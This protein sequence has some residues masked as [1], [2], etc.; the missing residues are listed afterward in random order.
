MNV[1]NEQ[2]YNVDK[3][4]GILKPMIYS[5]R[6]IWGFSFFFTSIFGG[7]LLMQNLKDIEKRKEANLVLVVSILLTVLTVVIIS[8]FN[9]QNRSVSFLCNIGA[10]GILTEIFY[11]KYFPDEADYDKKKI[12]KPLIIGICISVALFLLAVLIQKQVVS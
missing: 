2:D 1:A 11:K 8:F 12:W 10:A 6:A 3:L 4:E 7:I 5:K 9:I